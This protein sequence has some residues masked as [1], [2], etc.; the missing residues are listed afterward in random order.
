ME[1]TFRAPPGLGA[2]I[3]SN[4]RPDAEPFQPLDKGFFD[5]NPADGGEQEAWAPWEAFLEKKMQVQPKGLRNQAFLPRTDGSFTSGYRTMLGES[6]EAT[7]PPW[8]K[9]EKE[10]RPHGTSRD[11]DILKSWRNA[12]PKVP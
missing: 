9:Q 3:R 10:N 5:E 8:R 7:R 12:A 1:P 2:P 6:K 11:F 4:L